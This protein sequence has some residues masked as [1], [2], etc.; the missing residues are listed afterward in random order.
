MFFFFL[1]FLFSVGVFVGAVVRGLCVA[2]LR[3]SVNVVCVAVPWCFGSSGF[4][5]RQVLLVATRLKEVCS[6]SGH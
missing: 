1:F 6:F 4:P 5:R 3:F 2:S